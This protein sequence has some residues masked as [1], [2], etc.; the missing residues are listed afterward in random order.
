MYGIPLPLQIH[1]VVVMICH[2]DLSTL[3]H[4]CP[5]GSLR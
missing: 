4:L 3:V 5:Y 1:E 2:L